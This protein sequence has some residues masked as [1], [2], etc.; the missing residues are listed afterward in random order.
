MFRDSEFIEGELSRCNKC[1]YCM[2]S[3]PVYRS[4]RREAAVARGRNQVL[5]DVVQGEHEL[6]RQALQPFFDCLLCGACTV[7]CFGGVKTKELMV[8][9]REGYHAR[10]GQPA[11]QRYFFRKLL[12]NPSRLT[13][14]LRLAS[15]GKRSGLS[16]LARRA[17]LLRWL[18][19]TL[20]TADGLVA[21]MPKTF[22]RDRLGSLGFTRSKGRVIELSC[23]EPERATGPRVLYFIGCG[24]NFQL[25]QT[26][27]AAIRLLSKGGCHVT[28]AP[29]YCCGLPA[30]SYGDIEAARLLARQNLDLLDSLDFDLLVTEC[31]SCSGFLKEY[32]ALLGDDMRA[33]RLADRTRDITEVLATLSWPAP[34][35]ANATV[36]YHDP[37]HLS[38]G[39]EISEQPRRLL[40]DAG[41]FQLAEMAESNWCCGGAGSYNLSHPQMS[42]EILSRKLDRI[43]DTQA[44]VVATACPAC[45]I[46]I[47][48][49]VRS[50]G[51]ALPVRH[52]VE[53]V[54]AAQHP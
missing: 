5:R 8:R 54:A 38:R 18:N 4:V 27:E 29:N 48:C 20:H 31:G 7:D 24:P 13:R 16:G 19:P 12:P 14:L 17:G 3:C 53:L 40:V 22:L 35:P 33:R 32:P 15:L 30:W 37:C 42:Q 44:D 52:V 2:Q 36:T 26:A 41:G 11:I 6:P 47:G 1:G 25:P 10:Y 51:W 23:L 43:A 50:R 39:Q 9:A 45:I 46:Q 34:R 21:T 49:G 28:V